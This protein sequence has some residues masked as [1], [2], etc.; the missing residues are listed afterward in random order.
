MPE[1]V[2]DCCN[3][4]TNIKSK[5]ENHNET[6]KHLL[7]I[8]LLEQSNNIH[9]ETDEI[10]QELKIKI[11][12]LEGQIQV[13]KLLFPNKSE[14]VSQPIEKED[15]DEKEDETDKVLEGNEISCDEVIENFINSL[16]LDITDEL[17]ECIAELREKDDNL[18]DINVDNV[19]ETFVNNPTPCHLPYIEEFS[20]MN[21]E[22]IYSKIIMKNVL[23]VCSIDITEKYKGRFK[24]FSQGKWLDVEESRE[25]I[26]QLF[27]PINAHFKKYIKLLTYYFCYDSKRKCFDEFKEPIIKPITKSITRDIYNQ[28]EYTEEI[29]FMLKV[30]STNKDKILKNYFNQT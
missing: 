24:L 22:H 7:N 12:T 25:K 30:L 20:N 3:F 1:Y 26:I 10:I 17:K 9:K 8:S 23:S 14:V 18:Y 6:N 5:L 2:C 21:R 29:P 19:Y 16:E 28:L 15:E 13:Y 11:A 4:K 27:P